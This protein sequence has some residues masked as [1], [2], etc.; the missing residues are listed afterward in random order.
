MYDAHAVAVGLVAQ[1]RDPF[2]ALLAHQ[3]GDLLEQPRLVHL[4]G[5]LGDDDRL[6]L[7][8]AVGPRSPA[9]RAHPHDAAAGL[10]VAS[11]SP[12]GRR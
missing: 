12:G 2:D 6:A 11:R 5:E 1:V 7:A 4:V 9:R 8:A 10:D 3:L